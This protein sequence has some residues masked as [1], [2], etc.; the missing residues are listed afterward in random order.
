MGTLID[1]YIEEKKTF[2]EDLVLKFTVDILKGLNELHKCNIIHRDIKPRNLF[3]RNNHIVI[4]DLGVAVSLTSIKMSDHMLK[5]GGTLFY[6]APEVIGGYTDQKDDNLKK[7]ADIWSLACVVYELFTLKRAYEG[8]EQSIVNEIILNGRVP[9][10]EGSVIL[11]S[12]LNRMF[13]K[14]P[15]IRPSAQ[16]LLAIINE[17]VTKKNTAD[18]S[19]IDNV[20]YTTLGLPKTLNNGKFVVSTTIGKQNVLSVAEDISDNQR[21]LKK[22]C[23]FQ[24]VFLI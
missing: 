21:F 18:R 9:E 1:F 6:M 24:K 5:I 14:S 7:K 16:Q 20:I 10:V 4:G 15:Y 2:S 3:L 23:D 17:L 12:L 8:H 19:I 11:R 13:K 22:F